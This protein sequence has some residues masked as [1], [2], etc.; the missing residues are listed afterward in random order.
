[1]LCHDWPAVAPAV[2]AVRKAQEQGRLDEQ[3]SRSSLE[4]IERVCALTES[5]VPQPPLEIIG[6]TEHRA[7]AA[8][9]RAIAR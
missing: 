9:I 3:Q 2:A 8:E 1:M 5:D 6:C 4:R 7:L